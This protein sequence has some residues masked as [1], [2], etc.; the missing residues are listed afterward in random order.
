VVCASVERVDLH[1]DALSVGLIRT[2]DSPTAPGRDAEGPG[3]IWGIPPG[4]LIP[5]PHMFRCRQWKDRLGGNCLDQRFLTC[6]KP[7]LDR[8]TAHRPA[9]TAVSVADAK[10]TF[11]PLAFDHRTRT[12]AIRGAASSWA[13]H[14]REAERE[15]ESAMRWGQHACTISN[16][17]FT[18]GG[19]ASRASESGP[20]SMDGEA[21]LPLRGPVR[22]RA[23]QV[24]RNDRRTKITVG[25]GTCKKL[26]SRALPGR[27]VLEARGL[28]KDYTAGLSARGS[29]A[30]RR[31]LDCFMG[32]GAASRLL[33]PKRR[34]ARNH[35]AVMILGGSCR[36]TAAQSGVCG[37]D[38]RRTTRSPR[39][40][41]C[42][43]FRAE[44][45]LAGS[46]SACGWNEY[47]R[48]LRVS[49]TAFADSRSRGSRKGFELFR[50]SHLAN[51]MGTDCSSGQRAQRCVGIVASTLHHESC[52]ILER[53]GPRRFEPDVSRC[54]CGRAVSTFAY[55]EGV[56]LLMTRSRH[57]PTSSR[58]CER[59]LLPWA[60]AAFVATGRQ[61]Y[62]CGV[63]N[64][65]GNLEGCVPAA[66]RRTRGASPRRKQKR[67]NP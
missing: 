20:C 5:A 60:Q 11:S 56:A 44:G 59:V 30:H 64:G 55:N 29:T 53:A 62:D 22:F 63:S 40:R 34:R 21:R 14:G 10:P 61:A 43:G 24:E 18:G 48:L 9:R 49:S 37:F 16:C 36:P 17:V 33:G 25:Q 32:G 7:L 41:K 13:N 4:V 66:S 57:E 54:A 51:A 23:R 50:I 3:Q 1:D 6:R 67:I 8:K 39:P 15:V 52:F 45:Y 19:S 2:A 65:R 31:L 38:L 58:C 46:Q 35:D 27:V 47:L 12:S 26:P 28:L 42:I